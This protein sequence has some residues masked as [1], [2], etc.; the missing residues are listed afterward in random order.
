MAHTSAG[1]LHTTS[2]KHESLVE[3]LAN[4]TSMN[5]RS[6]Y[7]LLSS[8]YEVLKVM[9]MKL[10]FK[11]PNGRTKKRNKRMP[12][13]IKCLFFYREAR[14]EVTFFFNSA[15]DII[16]RYCVGKNKWNVA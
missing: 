9:F 4:S 10:G 3:S 12:P 7:L 6:S 14:N 13:E 11:F 1:L 15:I 2:L 16:F 8:R 5:G